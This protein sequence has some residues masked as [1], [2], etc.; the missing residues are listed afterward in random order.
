MYLNMYRWQ[1]YPIDIPCNQNG[2]GPCD[3]KDAHYLNY[4]V[5]DRHCNSHSSHNTLSAAIDAAVDL[6]LK[7]DPNFL[8]PFIKYPL[9]LIEGA[10]GKTISPVVTRDDE[11]AMSIDNIASAYAT[12]PDNVKATILALTKYA[13]I[14]DSV[15]NAETAHAEIQLANMRIERD[16]YSSLVTSEINASL[17]LNRDLI[18]AN[19]EIASLRKQLDAVVKERDDLKISKDLEVELTMDLEDIPIIIDP[20]KDRLDGFDINDMSLDISPTSMRDDNSNVGSK[21]HADECVS[22]ANSK[23]MAEFDS[24][25]ANVDECQDCDETKASTSDHGSMDIDLDIMER[26][27]KASMQE[28]FL[29]GAQ[30]AMSPKLTKARCKYLLSLLN[31]IVTS[32]VSS[33]LH[34]VRDEIGSITKEY[35]AFCNLDFNEDFDQKL[36]LRNNKLA[37]IEASV[38]SLKT[39]VDQLA[40]IDTSNA[41]GMTD[42]YLSD[43]IELTYQSS[44]SYEAGG[45]PAHLKEHW[46]EIKALIE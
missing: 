24:S 15:M 31:M 3:I 7:N 13:T 32:P 8:K 23:M 40:D 30:L 38:F 43:V 5:W 35:A 44:G 1:F 12:S 19:N 37:S 4:E 2:E 9:D 20:N 46:H 27:I 18:E 36:A 42:E 16:H 17:A 39:L 33:R 28:E 25:L 22:D 26:Q 34:S 29:T 11:K 21:Q 6:N 14:A 10:F 45:L 41:E